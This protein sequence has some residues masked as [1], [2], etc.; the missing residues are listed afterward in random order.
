MRQVHA[1]VVE[2]VAKEMKVVKKSRK[3]QVCDRVGVVGGEDKAVADGWKSQ[4]D[5]YVSGKGKG[6]SK[7][8]MDVL[9]RMIM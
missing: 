3:S 2:V 1:H 5:R 4:C 6:P 9:C 8:G 7:V